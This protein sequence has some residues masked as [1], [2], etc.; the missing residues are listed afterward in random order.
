MLL[1]WGLRIAWIDPSPEGGMVCIRA[2][3]WEYT[4]NQVI[5]ADMVKSYKGEVKVVSL[6]EDCSTSALVDKIREM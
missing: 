1:R 2:K 3:G 6:V 4:V 5:G